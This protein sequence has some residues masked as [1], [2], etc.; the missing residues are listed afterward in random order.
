MAFS[1]YAPTT[2]ERDLA[3]A[4]RELCVR[5]IESR[6]HDVACKQLGCTELALESLLWEPRWDLAPAF[7]IAEGLELEVVGSIVSQVG[8]PT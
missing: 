2:Q 8:S 5:A 4:L 1:V 6:G 3:A 7:R